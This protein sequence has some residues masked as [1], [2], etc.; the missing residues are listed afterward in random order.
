ME[1]RR[2]RGSKETGVR[3]QKK[4]QHVRRRRE[5]KGRR[6]EREGEGKTREEETVEGE[7]SDMKRGESCAKTKTEMGLVTAM[8]GAAGLALSPGPLPPPTGGWATPARK[9]MACKS[10]LWGRWAF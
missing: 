5:A 8:V 3:V 1:G 4:Y 2:K 10:G 7:G 9:G 6:E